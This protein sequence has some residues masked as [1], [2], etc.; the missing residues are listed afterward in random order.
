[1]SFSIYVDCYSYKDSPT[2]IDAKTEELR[3]WSICSIK[4]FSH[5]G[6]DALHQSFSSLPLS[7][8]ILYLSDSTKTNWGHK[9]LVIASIRAGYNC[10]VKINFS[11]TLHAP[12]TIS[13]LNKYVSNG[14]RLFLF[15]VL[16]FILNTN[17]QPKCC[18]A[19]NVSYFKRQTREDRTLLWKPYVS[20]HFH[21]FRNRCQDQKGNYSQG[22]DI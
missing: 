11:Q 13:F 14:C 2:V 1:M 21:R 4:N 20:S 10:K 16:A 3:N 19:L 12:K 9:Q 18:Y 22:N 7:I 17:F 15:N 5:A 6:M 8:S